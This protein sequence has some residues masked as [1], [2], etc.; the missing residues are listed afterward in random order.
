MSGHPAAFTFLELSCLKRLLHTSSCQPKMTSKRVIRSLINGALRRIERV[1]DRRH[2][3]VLS[4]SASASRRLSEVR[5]SVP[6]TA[7]DSPCRGP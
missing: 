3:T 5:P 6:K 7:C 2:K 4:W 1:P